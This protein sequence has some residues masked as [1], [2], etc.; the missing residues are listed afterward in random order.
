MNLTTTVT[1]KNQI[2]V[3]K[4]VREKTGIRTGA[5]LDIYPTYGG[6]V[7]RVRKLSNI[8]KF[9]GDLKH[10]DDGRPL[11]EIRKKAQKME[12]KRIIKKLTFK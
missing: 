2:T 8:Q 5:K 6:F 10:L 12:A 7:G 9:F 11:N 1:A 3:P 4:F